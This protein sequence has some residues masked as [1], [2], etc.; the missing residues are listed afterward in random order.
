MGI[1]SIGGDIFLSI[2]AAKRRI[3]EFAVQPRPTTSLFRDPAYVQGK[4]SFSLTKGPNG[5][6]ILLEINEHGRQA[7]LGVIES[8]SQQR[9]LLRLTG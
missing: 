4:V 8:I 5:K 2:N 6:I 1:T 9:L 3:T 7:V